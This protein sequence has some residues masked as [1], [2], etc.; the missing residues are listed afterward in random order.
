[1]SPHS[2]PPWEEIRESPFTHQCSCFGVLLP[3]NVSVDLGTFR[4]IQNQF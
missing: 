2:L 1:L 4:G 3:G